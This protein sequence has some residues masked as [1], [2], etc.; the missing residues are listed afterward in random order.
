LR[1]DADSLRVKI[2]AIATNGAAKRPVPRRTSVLEREV[3]AYLVYDL[4]DEI[5][6]GVIEPVITIVGDGRL[7]GRAIVDL[8]AVRTSRK[9]G[10]FDPMNLLTGR[11]P[12]TATGTLTSNA[13]VA[14]FSLE[15]ASI[16][17]VPVPKMVLQELVSYY[18][19]S[20]EH[21]DGI[22]LDD[23]FELPAAIKQIEVGKGQAVVV[24]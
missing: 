19:R 23:R 10:M 11:L 20:P 1:Q 5:P 3:N 7:A 4:K 6:I 18:S 2:S 17:G 22:G 16:S 24:Q 21:P 15:S 9:R 13:G 14:Q 8:D 12:V